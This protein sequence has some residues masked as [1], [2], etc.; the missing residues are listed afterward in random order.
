MKRNLMKKALIEKDLMKKT[1]I[2][3]DLMRKTLMEK[4]LIE[5]AQDILV[6]LLNHLLFIAAAI[7]I[8]DLFQAEA[9]WIFICC[10]TVL[11]PL[12]FYHMMHR[13][14]KLIPPPLFIVIL[15]ILSM[16]EKIK[17]VNDWQIY[18]F[19]I[20]FVY[21]GGYFLYYFT[22]Q[23]MQ[24]LLL[25]ESSASN[26]PEE[27]IYRNGMGQTVLFGAGSL[28][29]LWM[30]TNFDWFAKIM[31]HVW[32][33][34]FKIL[35]YL[36]SGIET[37]PPEESVQKE[38]VQEMASDF[39]GAVTG[40]FFPELL[41]NIAK[42]IATGIVFVS[43]VLGCMV[44]LYL[45]YSLIKEHFIPLMKKDNKKELKSSEDIR[46]YCGVEKISAKRVFSFPFWDHREKIR[47]LYQKK[48]LK[49]KRELI[50]ENEQGQLEYLT[51]KECCDRLSEQNLKMAYEKARYSEESVTAEDVRL[52]R[53]VK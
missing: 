25:N 26:I 42:T 41:Q 50:G 10:C 27:D 28:I 9:R 45:I 19:V 46:E 33:W 40:T 31:E 34:I 47:R 21:F 29:V 2:E 53:T 24:F 12:I 3:K 22:K 43:F 6:I 38:E 16:V 14:Q 44:M 48:V 37:F 35:R 1:L 17:H 23:F 18:Y 7:T 5:K 30:S 20:V 52:A 11:I 4:V 13:P 32:S 36:L 15:G 39:G 51:A 49:R 8:L